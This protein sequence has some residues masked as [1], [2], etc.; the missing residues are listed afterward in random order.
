MAGG[1]AKEEDYV[2]STFEHVREEFWGVNEELGKSWNLQMSSLVSTATRRL[3]ALSM[4]LS[5]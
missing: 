3:K 5:N 1:D 4:P 2:R